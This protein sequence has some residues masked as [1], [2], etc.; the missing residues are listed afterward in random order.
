[1]AFFSQITDDVLR[2]E[3]VEGLDRDDDDDDV[4]RRAGDEEQ[5]DQVTSS[6]PQNKVSQ[7]L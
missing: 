4:V 6:Q 1:M 3:V 2:G 5:G 7:N